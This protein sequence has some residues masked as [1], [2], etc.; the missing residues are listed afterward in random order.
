MIVLKEWGYKNLRLSPG[1][2]E[3]IRTS[4]VV[5]SNPGGIAWMILVKWEIVI[6]SS[7]LVYIRIILA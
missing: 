1:L 3:Y 6:E 7:A 2:E 4:I 5:D